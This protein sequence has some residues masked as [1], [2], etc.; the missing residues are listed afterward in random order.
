MPHYRTI[1]IFHKKKNSKIVEVVEIKHPNK[2]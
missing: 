2:Y 1:I